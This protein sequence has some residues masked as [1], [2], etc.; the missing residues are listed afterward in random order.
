MRQRRDAAWGR[1]AAFIAA[2]ESAMLP[3]PY[4]PGAGMAELVDARD[5]KSLEAMPREG[6]IPSPGTSNIKGLH[7]IPKGQWAHNF[8]DCA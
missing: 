8:I 6:S 2:A 4:Q 1:A 3:V 7:E 5:L